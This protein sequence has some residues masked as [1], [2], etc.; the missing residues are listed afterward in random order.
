[1]GSMGIEPKTS[2]PPTNPSNTLNTRLSY[3]SL[4]H[5]ELKAE[6]ETN[7]GST[8]SFLCL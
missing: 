4:A 3:P 1:M 6:M 8:L 2:R 7:A 5:S